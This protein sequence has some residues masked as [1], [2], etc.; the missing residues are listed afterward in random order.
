MIVSQE[1]KILA[2]DDSLGV[3]LDYLNKSQDKISSF[4]NT[5]EKPEDW[6]K[7]KI[8]Q[9][10]IIENG[11]ILR[12]RYLNRLGIDP[13]SGLTKEEM[14]IIKEME[15]DKIN[16]LQGIE[17]DSQLKLE[18]SYSTPAN[19]FALNYLIKSDDDLRKDYFNRLGI[20]RQ[21]PAPAKKHQSSILL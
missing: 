10:N 5:D 13:K 18:K 21:P 3:T 15:A 20:L 2:S 19:D 7:A 8:L 14:K 12:S 6:I 17:Y 9:N 4:L 16:K 11:I 1:Q